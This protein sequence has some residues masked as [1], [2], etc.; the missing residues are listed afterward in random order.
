MMLKG[1]ELIDRRLFLI[2]NQSHSPFFDELMWQ[3]SHQLIWSPLYLFILYY[4]QK[5]FNYKQIFVFFIGIG[6]CF[7][8]A[9]R[10]S[11]VAFK[12][13]FLRYRPTHNLEIKHLVH[14]Y[15]FSD[16]KSYLGGLYGFVSSHSANFF[17][18]S[19]F[20]FLNFRAKSKFW[21]YIFL[22]AIIIG[23]SRIYLGVHYPFDVVGGGLL[24]VVIGYIVYKITIF[25][26][27]Y[28]L[29]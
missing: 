19:M 5:H 28:L 25:I 11:V 2:I 15:T 7:L 6:L 13:V 16:G 29:R 18:L 22:W 10:L 17:A 1:L 20:L 24:G 4:L 3:F 23:Y 9:D 8:L 26:N 27:K 21:G 12:N 14:T